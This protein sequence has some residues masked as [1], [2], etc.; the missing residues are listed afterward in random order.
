MNHEVKNENEV[1]T[2]SPKRR[3]RFSDDLPNQ[4]YNPTFFD[5]AILFDLIL[6][7]WDFAKMIWHKS[8]KDKDNS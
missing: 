2:S 1:E 3:H 4:S 6:D 5:V 7:V 8:R